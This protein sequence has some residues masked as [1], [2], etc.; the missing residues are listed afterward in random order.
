MRARAAAY[1]TCWFISLTI[2]ATIAHY[3]TT[4]V[5]GNDKRLRVQGLQV[6]EQASQ[7]PGGSPV[8]HTT[9]DTGNRLHGRWGHTDTS[10]YSVT[11][12]VSAL[13]CYLSSPTLL[14]SWRSQT[15]R[16]KQ[17]Y[18]DF[19]G[20]QHHTATAQVPRERIAWHCSA[21]LQKL[22]P[23]GVAYLQCI[24]F[25]RGDVSKQDAVLWATLGSMEETTT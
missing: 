25:W 18:R 14:V 8:L 15:D 10:H 23:R 16:G 22:A 21:S 11:E 5:D 19:Q 6:S 4:Y 9:A 17:D 1:W 24:Q 12:H 3:Y 7:G 13:T 20:S 2:H